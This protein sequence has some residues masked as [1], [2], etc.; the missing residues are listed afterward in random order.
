MICQFL[1][2]PWSFDT[3]SW[4]SFNQY[5]LKNMFKY[6]HTQIFQTNFLSSEKGRKPLILE[7]WVHLCCDKCIQRL[8]CMAWFMVWS[9]AVSVQTAKATMCFS[10]NNLFPLKYW[11]HI[12]NDELNPWLN[13]ERIF[14]KNGDGFLTI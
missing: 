13:H 4:I 6:S 1:F 10:K 11:F 2:C 12:W 14:N 7:Y 8:I 5:K 9:K 3:A